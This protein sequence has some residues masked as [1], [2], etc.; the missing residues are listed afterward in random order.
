MRS[1]LAIRVIAAVAGA[2]MFE[3][4]DLVLDRMGVSQERHRVARAVLKACTGAASSSLIA[5][6]LESSEE[7]DASDRAST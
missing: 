2:L 3:L 4:S 6:T 7:K 5:A 1:R